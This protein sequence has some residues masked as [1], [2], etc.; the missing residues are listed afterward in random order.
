[1]G[2]KTTSE[3]REQWLFL[4]NNTTKKPLNA[5]QKVYPLETSKKKASDKIHLEIGALEKRLTTDLP[6]VLEDL[7]EIATLVYVAGQLTTRGG[8]KEI[9]YGYKW[10]RDFELVIPV[11]EYEIWSEYQTKELLEEILKFVSGEKYQFH[12]TRKPKGIPSFLGYQ[13]S[14]IGDTDIQEVVLF[15]GGMDSFSGVVKEVHGEKKKIALV[16][17]CS[18][19]KM[20]SLQKKVYQYIDENCEGP[21]PLHVPAKIWKGGRFVTKDTNQRNRSFLYAALGAAVAKAVGLSRV[22]F[23]ENGII[24]CNLP[25]D[26]QTYQARRTRTTHPR[27]LIQMSELMEAITGEEFLFENPYA[28]KTRADVI[29]EVKDV[30]KQEGIA[31]TRSCAKSRYVGK[32]RHDGVC[33]QCVDR[34][35]AVVASECEKCESEEEYKINIFTDELNLTHDRTMVLGFAYLTDFIETSNIDSFY[36]KFSSDLLELS[37]YIGPQEAAIKMIYNLYLR[38]AKQVNFAIDKKI[39][40]EP[41]IARRGHRDCLISMVCRQIHKNFPKLAQN[42]EAGIKKHGKHGLNQ[43]VQHHLDQDPKATAMEIARK[44]GN[45]SDDAVRQTKAWKTR[46]K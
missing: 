30:N 7:L 43:K 2:K 27:F 17:H 38:Y 40:E 37:R 41:R 23:Y 12:F 26:G 32:T 21:Q 10:Y 24:S 31:H 9:E 8:N 18:E 13:P 3:K 34:R 45:T 16:S 29:Q 6:D 15:S 5:N 19:A 4:C 46:Q 42:E 39:T 25:F 44:I 28:F 33:S 14:P 1:M 22:R 20:D 36:K 35:F 11:R